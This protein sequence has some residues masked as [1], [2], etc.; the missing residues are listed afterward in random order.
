MQ[1][2]LLEKQKVRGVNRD[3]DDI[4]S[5]T[6]KEGDALFD[7]GKALRVIKS[8]VNKKTKKTMFLVEQP[9]PPT[10]PKTSKSKGKDKDK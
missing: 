7:K 6:K 8:Y 2:K 10:P 4:V 3:K 5:V 1:V 9:E